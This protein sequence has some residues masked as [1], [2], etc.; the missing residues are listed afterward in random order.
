MSSGVKVAIGFLLFILSGIFLFMIGADNI[1]ETRKPTLYLFPAIPAII[2]LPILL[3]GLFWKIDGQL[4]HVIIKKATPKN[5][6][7]GMGIVIVSISILYLFYNVLHIAPLLVVIGSLIGVPVGV[8]IMGN[9]YS[10]ACANCHSILSNKSKILKEVDF[11]EDL[12]PNSE[13]KENDVLS[14]SYCP[15]CNSFVKIK[16]GKNV[17]LSEGDKA[18]KIHA[19]LVEG[20]YEKS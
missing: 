19:Y 17:H 20:N 14:F 9:V 4:K 18:N 11:R 5:L 12:P 8:I 3:S 16:C 1:E 2:A 10:E 6:F 15:M 13:F 7:I